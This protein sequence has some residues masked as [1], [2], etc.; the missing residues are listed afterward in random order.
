M[1][2]YF[3]QCSFHNTNHPLIEPA[4]PRGRGCYKGPTSTTLGSESMQMRWSLEL[5][6]QAGPGSKG[7][8]IVEI[9]LLGHSKMTGKLPHSQDEAFEVIRD[10]C[11]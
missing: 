11:F 8:G 10:N 2:K 4:L 5:L 1:R 9:E 6:Q 7:T 3:I